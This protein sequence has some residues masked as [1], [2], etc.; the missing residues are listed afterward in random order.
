MLEQVMKLLA[1]GW[2]WLVSSPSFIALVAIWA[3]NELWNKG[4][5]EIV[6]RI[7]MHRRRLMRTLGWLLLSF[8]VEIVLATLGIGY[9]LNSGAVWRYLFLTSVGSLLSTLFVML[10]LYRRTIHINSAH[11]EQLANLPG[12]DPQLARRIIDYREQNGGFKRVEDV[13]ETPGIGD[14]L[15]QRIK[16]KIR[17]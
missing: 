8:A 16:Y 17:V 1:Q 12:L 9:V 2:R 5:R 14:R 3:G 13:T 15:F 7:L 6:I 4:G 10:Y 11:E